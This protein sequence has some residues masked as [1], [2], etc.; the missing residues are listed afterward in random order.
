MDEK[1]QK[2]ISQNADQSQK[3]KTLIF[4]KY[5]L[6]EKLKSGENKVIQADSG[7]FVNLSYFK[8]KLLYLLHTVYQ[9]LDKES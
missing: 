6:E 8:T 3:L 1:N 5:N 7:D 4:E 9:K 2:L